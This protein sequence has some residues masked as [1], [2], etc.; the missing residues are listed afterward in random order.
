MEESIP[1]EA[2][3]DRGWNDPHSD[4]LE[5]ISAQIDA[6]EG[7]R[8]TRLLNDLTRTFDAWARFSLTFDTLLQ[9][10]ETHEDTVM[11]LVRNVGDRTQQ[12]SIVTG[13]DQATIAY[14]AGVGALVDQTRNALRLQSASLR[15]AEAKHRKD[16]IDPIPGAAFLTKLRNYVLHYVA[17]PWEFRAQMHD[18]NLTAKVLLSANELLKFDG[19]GSSAREFIESQSDGIQLSNLLQPFLSAMGD[20]TNWIFE[21]CASENVRLVD[22][23]NGLVAKKNLLLTGGATDGRD[24]EARMAHIA[25]NIQRSK[26]DEPQLDFRTGEPIREPE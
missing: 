4:A 5:E 22:E 7:A 6:H 1:T 11:A 12:R 10:C 26:R 15:E 2:E 18:D 21:L 9:A 17:A 13:L 19:W 14:A 20:H 8:R 3:E 24:W 23:V 16:F 25:E